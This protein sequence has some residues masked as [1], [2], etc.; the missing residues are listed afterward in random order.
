MRPKSKTSIRFTVAPVFIDMEDGKGMQARSVLIEHT[1]DGFGQG[2]IFID[3][4]EDIFKLKA[5]IDKYI[6]RNGIEPPATEKPS[7]G[8]KDGK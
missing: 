8:K 3:R 6:R 4:P 5:A 2:S 1:V 7:R